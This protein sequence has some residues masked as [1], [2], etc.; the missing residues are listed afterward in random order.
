[1][2]FLLEKPIKTLGGIGPKVLEKLHRLG[3][4]TVGDLIH[5]FPHRYE[6]FSNIKNIGD[7]VAEEKATVTGKIAGIKTIRTWKKR[8]MVTEAFASD[9]TGVIRLV[10]FNQPYLTQ[11]LKKDL[12]VSFSGKVALDNSGLYFS[13]P[14]FEVVGLEPSDTVKIHTG[15]LVPIYPETRGLTSRWLRYKIHSVLNQIKSFDD[16]LPD[17]LIKELKLASRDKALRQIHFPKTKEEAEAARRRLSFEELFLLQLFGAL[18][19]KKI[20]SSPAPKIPTNVPLIKK[21]VEHLPFRL[22]DSQRLAAWQIL[23]DMEAASPMNRL[24]EGDVGSGKTV[25]AAIAALNAVDAGWQAAFMAPT[26]ILAQQH[27]KTMSKMFEE[28]NYKVALLTGSV[29]KKELVEEIASGKTNIVV[30]THALIQKEV[31]FPKLGLVVTDE[32][33]RFGVDQRAH[34]LRGQ[35]LI[36]HLLSMTAT[37]IPRTL[38]LILY[39]D[40]DLSLIKELPAGRKKILTKIV[41]PAKRPD[42]YGFIRKQIKEGRQVFVIC[43]LIEESQALEV[44]SVTQE[45][46]KLSENIFPDLG[47][48]MLHGKLK[49]K[50]KEEVMRAFKDGKTDLLVSTAVVE[51][52]I[53]VPNASVMM[54][55]GAERFGLAQLHQFRGRVGRAE[56]QSYCFLFTDSSAKT[57]QHRLKALVDSE[58]GFALAEKD[59]QIRGPGEFF[60]TKQ[61]GLPD[62]AMASLKDVRLIEEVQL[63]VKKFLEKSDISKYPAL[64]ARLV[65][66]QRDIHWE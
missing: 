5:H 32:Q 24:L 57:T 6:D 23:K 38:A 52:G 65:Q 60:G 27:F 20:K 22:T 30:G 63:A 44:R 2:E 56:H 29:P 47:V 17:F 59:L 42:A 31:K 34:L 35:K 58:D 37:P 46:E 11:T 49:P 3:L 10:W 39:G 55:E 33:H 61:S 66:F 28:T 13:N 18:E 7:L 8:M 9:K 50:E 1:M 43:P 4:K 26:E 40:L 16:F 45:H 62:L 64:T 15:G 54:I 48:A 14:V 25:V 19:R 41:P 36:P 12:W 53:D 21:F 51:V